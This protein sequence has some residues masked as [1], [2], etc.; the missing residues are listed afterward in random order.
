MEPKKILTLIH[1]GARLIPHNSYVFKDQASVR[2][3]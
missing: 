1:V 2:S 3:E